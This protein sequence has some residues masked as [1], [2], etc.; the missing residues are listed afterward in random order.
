MGLMYKL[1]SHSAANHVLYSWIVTKCNQTLRGYYKRVH[2]VYIL[3]RVFHSSRCSLITST[4]LFYNI[5]SVFWTYT[6]LGLTNR[7][8]KRTP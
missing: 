7:K 4:V 2:W 8:M 3:K 1:I 6:K 5:R